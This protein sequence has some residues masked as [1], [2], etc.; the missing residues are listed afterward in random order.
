M[1]SSLGRCIEF[2]RKSGLFS[3]CYWLQCLGFLQFFSYPISI[4]NNCLTSY[5]NVW[6]KTNLNKKFL[7]ID[8]LN[9]RI[10]SSEFFSTN[11]F[12]INRLNTCPYFFH[13][14]KP[15]ENI[16]SAIKRGKNSLYEYLSEKFQMPLPNLIK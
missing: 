9:R 6:L 12:I 3:F 10:F 14:N 5:C 4:R 11:W 8:F 13:N 15:S 2:L 1:L 16:H 7:L